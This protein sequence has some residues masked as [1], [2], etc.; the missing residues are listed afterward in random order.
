MGELFSFS[1]VWYV[2]VVLDSW[3]LVDD[4]ELVW[5]VVVS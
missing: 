4:L 3:L 2:Q 1:W 5:V